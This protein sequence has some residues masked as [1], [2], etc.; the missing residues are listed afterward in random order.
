MRSLRSKKGVL[1]C[2]TVVACALALLA[3][4]GLAS[5]DVFFDAPADAGL[6]AATDAASGVDATAG[7]SNLGTSIDA[8]NG[9]AIDSG[10]QRPQPDA[11]DA[12]TLAQA[13]AGG[14]GGA[15]SGAGGAG[16]GSAGAG[17]S[18]DAGAEYIG[19]SVG[20]R[21]GFELPIGQAKSSALGDVVKSVVPIGIDLGYYLR[22]NLYIGGYFLYGFATPSTASEDVC[23]S[24]ADTTCSA[25]Q[26]RFG[27]AAEY[28]FRHMRTVSP[29]VRFGIGLDVLNLT[30]TDSTGATVQSAH[31]FG[32]DWA[33]LSAG[34][35]LKPGYY[36]GLGPYAELALG[37]YFANGLADPH[38]WFTLGLRM[39]TGLFIP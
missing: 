12:S 34:V 2:A 31:L 9:N 17:Y 22:P 5:A 15:A 4:G 8:G 30:A 28:I 11:I 20:L 38:A 23:P 25:V 14:D 16:T 3:R 1:A 7:E 13:Q 36:Y 19:V 29:W 18:V 26:Y 27:L 6:D 37:D 21:G 33:V 35:E 32:I 39:R 24:G 10:S